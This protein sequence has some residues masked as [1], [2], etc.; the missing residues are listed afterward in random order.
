M[1]N[2]ASLVAKLLLGGYAFAND[3]NIKINMTVLTGAF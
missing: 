1:C 3:R 2:G